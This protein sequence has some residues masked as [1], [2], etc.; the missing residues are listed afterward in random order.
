MIGRQGTLSPDGRAKCPKAVA[1]TVPSVKMPAGVVPSPSVRLGWM[2]LRP[3]RQFVSSTFVHPAPVRSHAR[4]T[5]LVAVVRPRASPTA[6]AVNNWLVPAGTHDPGE[7]RPPGAG[8]GAAHPHEAAVAANAAV[9]TPSS[10]DRR[11]SGRR[12]SCWRTGDRAACSPFK[13]TAVR[14]GAPD[15]SPP[16]LCR[17]RV[18][19]RTHRE[20][21]E[22]TVASL[23]TPVAHG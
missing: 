1:S 12:S 18:A 15:P 16:A 19:A 6:V 4:N 14:L 7:V 22:L 8:G 17:T 3:N 2:P 11:L 21:Q 10:N 23:A 13:V 5:P 9:P 20:V